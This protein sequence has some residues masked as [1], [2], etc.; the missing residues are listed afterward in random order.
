MDA[1]KSIIKLSSKQLRL[2][3]SCYTPILRT[4]RSRDSC[5]YCNRQCHSDHRAIVNAEIAFLYQIGQRV[6][7]WIKAINR[8]SDAYTMVRFCKVCNACSIRKP[9]QW[10][11]SYS[12]KSCA[13]ERTK[14]VRA[15]Y[16]KTDAFKELKRKSR[17]KRRAIERGIHA[18]SIDPIKVFERDK[19]VCHMCG[20]KTIKSKRGTYDA[21]APELDHIITLH[22]GGQHTYGNVACSCRKCNNAKSAKS[23]GQIGFSF[24]I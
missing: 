2:C 1:I 3:K 11:N 7:R 16:I 14:A 24:A 21:L 20:V 13:S 10:S 8:K 15:N 22:D 4:K 12:C 9:E 19:W 6:R 23:F 5:Q 17:S 18:D